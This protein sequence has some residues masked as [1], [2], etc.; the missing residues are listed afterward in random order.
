MPKNKK[1]TEKPYTAR[2]WARD[3]G[4]EAGYKTLGSQDRHRIIAALKVTK[5]G[6]RVREVAAK[7]D[8][9]LARETARYEKKKALCDK[10]IEARTAVEQ[11]EQL[12]AGIRADLATR[13]ASLTAPV[14]AAAA[15]PE[16]SD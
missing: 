12:L 7:A 5:R 3:G 10:Q 6:E 2:Q 9:R 13:S 4:V 14:G 1:R 16:A 11:A 8:E 15:S